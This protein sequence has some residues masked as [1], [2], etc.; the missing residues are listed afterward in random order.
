M[1]NLVLFSK[2]IDKMKMS[3]LEVTEAEVL[4]ELDTDGQEVNH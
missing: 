3:P 2:T 1:V 4:S